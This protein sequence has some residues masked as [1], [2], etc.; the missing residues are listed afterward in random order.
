MESLSQQVLQANENHKNALDQYTRKL[1][2]ELDTVNNLIVCLLVLPSRRM[3]SNILA[4]CCRELIRGQ[5][6]RGSRGQ[7]VSPCRRGAQTK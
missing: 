4:G 3:P 6:S 5:T 2:R 7:M 1:Q